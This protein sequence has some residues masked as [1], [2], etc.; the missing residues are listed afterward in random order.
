MIPEITKDQLDLLNDTCGRYEGVFSQCAPI[1]G[2]FPPA[3]A[4][5]LEGQKDVD[6]LVELGLLKSITEE[7]KEQIEAHNKKTG[8]VWQGYSITPL[9]RAMFQVQGSTATN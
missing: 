8:R 2:D 5:A 1:P 3:A 6:Y 7:N 4:E 9:G